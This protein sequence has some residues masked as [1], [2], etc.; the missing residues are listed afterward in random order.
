MTKELQNKTPRG[1]LNKLWCIF[2]NFFKK[3]PHYPF[4]VNKSLKLKNLPTSSSFDTFHYDLQSILNGHLLT[5]SGFLI[6]IFP[7]I[8]FW[9]Q[10]SNNSIFNEIH[11][12][13]WLS[14]LGKMGDHKYIKMARSLTKIWLTFNKDGRSPAWSGNITAKR[15]TNWAQN[16]H[17]LFSSADERFK[18]L[19]HKSF[20]KQLTYLIKEERCLHRSE[21]ILS[22][23]HAIMRLSPKKERK[24]LAEKYSKNFSDCE[25]FRNDALIDLPLN[26]ILEIVKDSNG[27]KLLMLSYGMSDTDALDKLVS[28]CVDMVNSL[29]HIDGSLASFGKKMSVNSA[30][31]K[32][33][34]S[35]HLYN[36]IK[37]AQNNTNS[38]I[39]KIISSPSDLIIDTGKP[40]IDADGVLTPMNFEYNSHGN[41][42][43]CSSEIF[44]EKT[45]STSPQLN[46]N[47][48]NPS[49]D[50]SEIKKEVYEENKN[51]WFDGNVRWSFCDEGFVLNRQI[52]LSKGGQELRCEDRISHAYG[53]STF[54]MFSVPRQFKITRLKEVN[55]FVIE[56]LPHSN[57]QRITKWAWY[58][59]K[60][61]KFS[62][63]QAKKDDT[64]VY[65]NNSTKIILPCSRDFDHTVSRWSLRSL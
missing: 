11:S 3:I 37:K 10:C 29:T 35:S 6:K 23:I 61:S 34:L 19:M 25:V 55:G 51:I 30:V 26:K 31:V 36:D 50:F 52:Y 22:I 9:K 7:L 20:A 44:I 14:S 59:S 60:E 8:N 13:Q 41:T 16:Y 38:R 18:E 48:P 56:A 57:N 15:L 4:I 40:K 42:I 17:L 39:V 27:I 47:T 63:I 54:L 58:F 33:F 65:L 46:T 21:D 53:F 5:Q 64:G 43:I 24:L 12:F 1:K 28:E 2:H 32:D 45:P 49:F 62:I